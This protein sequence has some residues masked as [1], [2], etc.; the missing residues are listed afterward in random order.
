ML[1]HMGR[2]GAGDEWV[3]GTNMNIP[4]ANGCRGQM[5]VGGE[6]EYT[7]DEWVSGTNMNIPRADGCHGIY[8]KKTTYCIPVFLKFWD[9]KSHFFPIC[10]K[11]LEN[12]M[13]L[14]QNRA[15]MGY[16]LP[17]FSYISHIPGK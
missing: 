1:Y 8:M 10:H 15:E 5:G 9:K 11:R 12:P 6:Y 2:M 14:A 17:L 7:E 3:P 4:R 13:I 16:K